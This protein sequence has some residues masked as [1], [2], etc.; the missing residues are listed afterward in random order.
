MTI[1]D[2]DEFVEYIKYEFFKKR[3]PLTKE[4]FESIIKNFKILKKLL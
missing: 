1:Q 4:N 2:I 3:T